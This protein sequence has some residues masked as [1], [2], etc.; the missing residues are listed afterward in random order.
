MSGEKNMMKHIQLFKP[1][2]RKEEVLEKMGEL[3]DLG[4]IGL[5][6]ETQLFEKEFATYT[7]AT[8]AIA[9]NSGTAALHLAVKALNLEPGSEVITTPITFVSTNHVLLYERLTPVFADVDENGNVT[10]ESV[11][12]LITPKTKAIVIVHYG[13][14]PADIRG[15]RRLSLTYNIP[16]I[17]DCAHAS[18][19]KYKNIM[20]GGS[21][22]L[23]CF[24]F[25]AVKTL[26]CGDGGMI[27]TNNK[28]YAER[29][30]KLRWL[31]I[32]KD[33]YSRTESSIGGVGE[34]KMYQ[35]EY[36]VDEVGYKYHM[37]DLT[38]AI[39]RVGLRYL[40]KDNNRRREIAKM[41]RE[42]LN[43]YY[44]RP[45]PHKDVHPSYHIFSIKS[46]SRDILIE[47]LKGLNIGTGVHYYPNNLYSMYKDCRGETPN[48]MSFYKT[49]ISLPMHLHLTDEDVNRVIEETNTWKW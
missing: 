11:E 23:C 14:I 26:P 44:L 30:K 22:N 38:A 45:E 3:I 39:G 37:N 31:G 13:G 32:S 12:K 47:H 5:G 1:L 10:P 43:D 17:E 28:F 18:G 7:G 40:E 29:L 21:E 8:Y 46:H 2:I 24:S 36:G 41:Y 35:W 34:K 25:H 33:T 19:S 9:L 42:G 15:F 48:A 6:A 27:T 20:I 49:T 16:I 4:W